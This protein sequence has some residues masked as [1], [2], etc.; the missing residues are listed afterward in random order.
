VRA[1]C[2]GSGSCSN[3][4]GNGGRNSIVGPNLF[5]VDFSVHKDFAVAKV[6]EAFKVQFRTEFFNVLNHANLTPL[7]PFFGSSNAQIFNPDGTPSGGG[8]C[9]NRWRRGP[10]SFSLR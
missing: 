10:G 6:S 8:A 3:L 2:Q 9:S 5:N 7:L 1:L 4:L